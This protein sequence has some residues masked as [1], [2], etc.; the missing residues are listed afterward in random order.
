MCV[1]RFLKAR[2]CVW[3]ALKTHSIM[4]CAGRVWRSWLCTSNPS[5]GGKVQA[6]VSTVCVC[7][8]VRDG[9]NVLL[10]VCFC[11]CGYETVCVA[12]P[13]WGVWVGFVC[14]TKR[15]V[16]TSSRTCTFIIL[17]KFISYIF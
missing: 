10:Y 16:S 4:T 1:C 5:P 13:V 3:P 8:G 9:E 17:N 12:L 6:R 14:Q 15:R 2:V 11:C 7:E